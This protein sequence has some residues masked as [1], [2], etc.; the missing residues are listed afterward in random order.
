MID[1]QHLSKITSYLYATGH[2]N[3][4]YVTDVYE[5]GG[6]GIPPTT[7]VS[8]VDINGEN[9]VNPLDLSM[10]ELDVIVMGMPT[11][12][13]PTEEEMKEFEDTDEIS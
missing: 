1:Q 10:T 7:Y 12:N 5:M 13:L 2:V 9:Q 4:D 11:V 3:I 8:Y 6:Y